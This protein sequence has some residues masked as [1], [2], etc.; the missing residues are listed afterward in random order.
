MNTVIGFADQ[1]RQHDGVAQVWALSVS[2]DVRSMRHYG[3][4]LGLGILPRSSGIS[5]R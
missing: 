3:S 1:A 2:G 4:N 5:S